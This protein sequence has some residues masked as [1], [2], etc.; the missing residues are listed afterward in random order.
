MSRPGKFRLAGRR[1]LL[2]SGE[3]MPGLGAEP[4]NL[5]AKVRGPLQLDRPQF[6]L[7]NAAGRGFALE[8]RPQ[9][10]RIYRSQRAVSS[11]F[12]RSMTPPRR[13]GTM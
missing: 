2:R 4:A 9:P 1:G 7:P 12:D 13:P 3:Y 10:E 5:A 6:P 11:A 8:L